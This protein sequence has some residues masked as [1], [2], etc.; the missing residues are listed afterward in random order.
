MYLYPQVR[1]P[2][3]LATGK[4]GKKKNTNIASGAWISSTLVLD[5]V[6]L[7]HLLRL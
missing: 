6:L 4:K 3:L 2:S 7:L 5:P 1:E